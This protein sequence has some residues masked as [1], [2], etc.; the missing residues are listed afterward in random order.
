[1]N[2]KIAIIGMDCLVNNCLGLDQFERSI[3]EGRQHFPSLEIKTE[4]AESLLGKV[5]KTSLA[6]ANLRPETKIGLIVVS[7]TEISAKCS[8]YIEKAIALTVVE[9]SSI[10]ALNLAENIL[11]S[12][13]VDAVLIASL[14]LAENSRNS[15]KISQ[16]V[17]TLSY[18]LHGETNDLG[19]GVVAVVLQSEKTA[20][21]EK[22]T[23][24]C[25]N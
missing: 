11:M 7:E 2:K 9:K 25:D 23:N 19:F 4:T 6:D 24:I 22:Q 10:S 1:M 8:D 13:Q 21:Q 12:Q 5:V 18:D 20:K 3:Y 15:A 14:N 17:Q 16:K